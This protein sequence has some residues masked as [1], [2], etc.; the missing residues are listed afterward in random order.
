MIGDSHNGNHLMTLE[1][2]AEFDPFL[3]MHIEHCANRRS[4]SANYLSKTVC[5]DIMHLRADKVRKHIGNEIRKTKYFS[6]IVDSTPDIAHVDQ[7]TLVI[8][9]CFERKQ[10]S[11]VEGS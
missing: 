11:S 8:R 10:E 2:I 5:D 1:L 3:V 9:Y 4:R 7:Q 6:S